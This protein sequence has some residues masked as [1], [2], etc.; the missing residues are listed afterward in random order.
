MLV[1]WV[2]EVIGGSR[3]APD[4]IGGFPIVEVVGN[5]QLGVRVVRYQLLPL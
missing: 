5:S 2:V 3:S 4:L 1:S